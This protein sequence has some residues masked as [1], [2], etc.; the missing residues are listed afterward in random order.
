MK[1]RGK[2]ISITMKQTGSDENTVEEIFTG[3]PEKNKHTDAYV[4]YKE[5]IARLYEVNYLRKETDTS[6]IFQRVIKVAPNRILKPEMKKVYDDCVRLNS[7]KNS[8]AVIE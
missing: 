8:C 4:K 1:I 6:Y 3:A 5:L 7:I 2:K